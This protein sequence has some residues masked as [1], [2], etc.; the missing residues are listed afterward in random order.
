M[1]YERLAVDV[2]E[3]TCE[4]CSYVWRTFELPRSC[5]SC[6]SRSWDVVPGAV[7]LGRP[8]SAGKGE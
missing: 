2:Y 3:C 4:R 7:P 6:K 1:S 8:K 5:A